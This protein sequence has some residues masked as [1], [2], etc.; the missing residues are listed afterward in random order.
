[1]RGRRGRKGEKEKRRRGEK[2]KRRRGE[3]ER[4]RG[5]ERGAKVRWFDAS[6]IG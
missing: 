4:G 2:E 1:V 3:G 6:K 5:G